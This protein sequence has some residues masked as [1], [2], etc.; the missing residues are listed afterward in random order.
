MMSRVKGWARAIGANEATRLA[1]LPALISFVML[2]P[3]LLGLRVFAP[4]DIVTADP[5]LAERRPG[6]VHPPAQNPLLG[7]VVDVFLP[8]K[9]YARSEIW[10]GRFPLWNPYNGLGS[11][12]HASLQGQVLSPFNLLWLLL[13]PLWGLGA[14]AALKWTLCGLGMALL[15]RA[16]GLGMLPAVF[17]S[18]ALQLSGPVLGWLQWPIGEGLMWVPWMLLAS[19]R[20]IDTLD[21]RWAAALAFF[22]TGELLAG[23]IE[24][25][26][27]SL[28]FLSV[29]AL[30]ALASAGLNYGTAVT[31]GENLS[32][33]LRSTAGK[34]W[35]G[36]LGAGA[37]GLSISA[38]QMLPFLDALPSSF[39]WL[40]RAGAQVQ[41]V[42]MPPE[43]ALMWLSPNGF[44]W[45]DAYK[46]PSN[47]V[48]TNPYVGAVTLLLAIWAPVG[49]T[50]GLRKGERG[51]A[52]FRLLLSPR[53]PYFWLGMLL[54]S[55]SMA[56]GI[57]PLS[58]LRDLP[59]F[60]TSFNSRL[61]SVSGPCVIVL[62]AMGLESLLAARSQAIPRSLRWRIVASLFVLAAAFFLIRGAGVWFVPSTDVN[63]YIPA[64]INWAGFLFC[65][66]ATLILARLV[67]L[68]NRRTFGMLMVGLVL[69]EMAKAGW[70]FNPTTPWKSFYPVN[71]LTKFL[72]EHGPQ[73]RVAVTGSSAEANMLLA[74][75]IAD[76]RIYD[77]MQ[78]SRYVTHARLV[79]PETFRTG[80]RE[81]DAHYT[82][83]MLLLKPNAVQMAAVGIRWLVTELPDDPKSWQPFP[84]TGPIYKPIMRN[85]GFAA[86][87]NL[88]AQP[89][90]RFANRYQVTGEEDV[91][92]RRM[93][94]LTLDRVDQAH[95]QADGGRL[96]VPVSSEDTG[97][98]VTQDEIDHLKLE[99]HDP[100]TLHVTA[101]AEKARLLV[102]NEAWSKDWQAE[103][104]GSPTPIYKVN[105]IV[106]GVIVPQGEHKITLRYDPPAFRWG[107]GISLAGLA[108]WLSLVYLA[109]RNRKRNSQ[110][111]VTNHE[112]PGAG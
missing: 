100:G 44:G 29:F 11:T 50:P 71:A 54:V 91:I 80:L 97:E 67:G 8:W 58:V 70:N 62:A 104:D 101:R 96:P 66:G 64:W 90:I 79:T 57:P 17:G 2:W 12:L 20:W 14:V 92:L 99:R 9:L 69:I 111:L 53:R 34:R 68:L 6:S 86:W 43:G 25:T 112:S 102:V 13:P 56:Y 87:E 16:L 94:A 74:L 73:E 4:T 30:A 103:I 21:L 24:T 106:Q 42:A 39:Q 40:V 77:P 1:V 82:A 85:N 33:P 35:L 7:D 18:V 36:L 31:I 22:V 98:P 47:W 5:L 27:H 95:V 93:R 23:H 63:G 75:R 60:N 49:M 46:G 89:Y 55:I 84:P 38:A 109:L 19:L 105:Y 72:I 15:L 28:A 52:A 51:R 110:I 45:P 107:V 88:Y 78:S 83:H 32:R 76:Y 59:G 41:Y 61:V 3:A 37:L 108:A 26:F 65:L 48:E 10:Q 81:Q